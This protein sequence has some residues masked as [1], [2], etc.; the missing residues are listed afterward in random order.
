MRSPPDAESGE[1]DE[2]DVAP[3]GTSTQRAEIRSA[4]GVRAVHVRS[5]GSILSQHG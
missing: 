5:Y 2:P 3:Y 1:P 4:A